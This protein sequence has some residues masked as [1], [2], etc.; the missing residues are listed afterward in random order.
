MTIVQDHLVDQI[1]VD[2][3]ETCAE[4]A[5]ARLRRQEKD[6]RENRAAVAECNGRIDVVLDLFLEVRRADRPARV[7]PR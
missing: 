3:T 4:L 7:N 6:S 5:R 2:F 1:S